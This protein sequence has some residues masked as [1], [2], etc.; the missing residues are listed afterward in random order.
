[1][2]KGAQT[3]KAILA[4]AF[5]L[6]YAQGY[7]ATSIDEILKLTHVTKGSFF[8]HFKHKDEMGLAMIQEILYPGMRKGMIE[9]LVKG[10]DPI[11]EIYKMVKGLLSDYEL[12]NVKYGCPAVNLIEEMAPLNPAFHQTL[13]MLTNEWREA[14]EESLMDAQSK[15]LIGPETDIKKVSL[16]IV[17]GYGGIRNLGK[18]YGKSCYSSFLSELKTYLNNL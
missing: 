10:K 18:L 3:R 1:M 4:A 9:P 16:F 14:I 13:S 15:G 12:F 7:Q 6:T 5:E 8:H 17:A 2:A 11:K